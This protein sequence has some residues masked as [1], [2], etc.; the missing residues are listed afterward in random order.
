[1]QNRRANKQMEIKEGDQVYVKATVVRAP[2]EGQEMYRLI[3]EDG[4]VVWAKREELV[5]KE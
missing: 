5:K 2:K 4:A 1:M 3:K